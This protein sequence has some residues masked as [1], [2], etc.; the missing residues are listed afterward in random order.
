MKWLTLTLLLVT[1]ACAAS[2]VRVFRWQ[3]WRDEKTKE[4]RFAFFLA[5]YAV[6]ILLEAEARNDQKTVEMLAAKLPKDTWN[7]GVILNG[8][9]T[10]YSKEQIVLFEPFPCGSLPE[11]VSGTIDVDWRKHTIRVALKVIV[12]KSSLNFVGNGVYIFER[13]GPNQRS[14]TKV[15]MGWLGGR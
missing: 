9:S 6:E 15:D 14:Q 10:S 11:I 5:P 4:K 7:Y 2:D 1:E 3:E 8:E 13:T 12:N